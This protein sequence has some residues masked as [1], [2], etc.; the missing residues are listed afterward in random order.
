[1]LA[2]GSL[3]RADKASIGFPT[4]PGLRASVPEPDFIMPVHD[5]DWGPRFNAI[6]GSGIASNAPPRIKQVLPMWAPKVDADGNERGGVPVVLLDAPLGTYVGWNVT[7]GGFHKDQIC[8]YVGG[9][10]PFART[11]AER[12]AVNDPR[13]SLEERYGSH[14][15]YVD[16]VRAAAARAMEQR[17]LLPE[18]AQALIEAARASAVLR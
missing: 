5:Y 12:R 9:M 13:P 18:D 4:L 1:M 14:D 15:G 17:F 16:K 7:A 8:N 6:D 3:A 2:D 11:A 10:V